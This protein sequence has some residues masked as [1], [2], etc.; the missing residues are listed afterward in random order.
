M[1]HRIADFEFEHFVHWYK[2][3]THERTNFHK[4]ALPIKFATSLQRFHWFI[5]ASIH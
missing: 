4:A 5:F 1:L 3:H 2:V